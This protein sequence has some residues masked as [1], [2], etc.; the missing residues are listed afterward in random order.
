M[1]SRR[2]VLS[3][4]L[5][6]P[7]LSRARAASFVCGDEPVAVDTLR[8]PDGSIPNYSYFVEP[9]AEEK[10][11]TKTDSLTALQDEMTRAK[12]AAANQG[13]LFGIWHTPL[14]G[15][16]YAHTYDVPGSSSLNITPSLRPGDLTIAS[17]ESYVWNQSTGLW[18]PWIKWKRGDWDIMLI[19][20]G[21]QNWRAR[22]ESDGRL[23][24]QLDDEHIVY[25]TR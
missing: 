21:K 17:N 8:C 7:A 10:D 3:T 12:N 11:E 19:T 13:G 23:K 24:L 14:S 6:A 5:A 9:P 15:T 22:L 4:L 25:G 16:P 18:G 2:L 1:A 20:G